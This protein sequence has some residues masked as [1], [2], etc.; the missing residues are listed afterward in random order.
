M[1]RYTDRH[2]APDP[3]QMTSARGTAKSPVSV[4][5]TQGTSFPS[6]NQQA[7]RGFGDTKSG[8]GPTWFLDFPMLSSLQPSVVCHGC[9]EGRGEVS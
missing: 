2:R 6:E 3:I 9:G 8:V 4:R 1:S 5:L 7:Q